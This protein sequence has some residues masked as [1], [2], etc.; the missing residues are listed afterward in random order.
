MYGYVYKITNLVNSK[1]YIGQHKSSFFDESYWGSGTLLK[2]VYEKYGKQNFTREILE[3]CETPEELNEREI[4]WISYYNS[5]DKSIGYN[6]SLGG[7]GAILIG[8]DNGMYG[9]HHSQE[10]ADKISQT[11]KL[12]YSTG[13]RQPNHLYGEDNGMYGKHHSQESIKKMSDSQ[14]ARNWHWY[15]N[16]KD[17]VQVNSDSNPPE[18]YI[19]GYTMSESH[20]QSIQE[21]WANRDTTGQNNNFYGKHHS[22]DTCFNIS[23]K[24]KSLKRHWYTNGKDNLSISEGDP[25]PNGYLRGFTMSEAA[26]QKISKKNSG[27]NN[28][29]YGKHH[30]ENTKAKISKSNKSASNR[31]TK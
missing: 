7:D 6:V 28:G 20:L 26:K 3:F 1:I 11:S 14:L 31:K 4:F 8:E 17:N 19:L 29:F 2:S 23:S 22:K 30:S 12:N 9:N 25:I 21:C 10:S 24:L 15:T 13:K 27:S 18:G 16:G 5:T